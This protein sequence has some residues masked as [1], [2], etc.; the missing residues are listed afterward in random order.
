MSLMISTRMKSCLAVSIVPAFAVLIALH[1]SYLNTYYGLS[2]WKGGGMG[3]FAAADTADTR[4]TRIYLELPDGS[5][6]P[7][8][9]PT[10]WQRALIDRA[11]F[12]PAKSNFQKIATSMRKTNWQGSNNQVFAI[13]VDADGNRLGLVGK[14][15]YMLNAFGLR[16]DGAEPNWSLIIEYWNTDYDP[17]TR[18]A[19]ARLVDTMRF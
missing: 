12:Y 7:I 8:I 6:Q 17:M 10:G 13:H 2:T 18:V 9:N 3:M 5:R 11:M 1:Q 19:H 15:F 14:P 16:S 4:F